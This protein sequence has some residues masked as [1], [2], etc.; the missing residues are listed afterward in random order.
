MSGTC[1]RKVSFAI[2]DV[3]CLRAQYRPGERIVARVTVT[4]I[5]GSE[6]HGRLV[7]T[8]M[9]LA[10]A[11]EGFVLPLDPLPRGSSIIEVIVPPPRLELGVYGSFGLDLALE[12][13]GRVH[14][15]ASTAFDVT[16]TGHE[17]VRYGFLSRFDQRDGGSDGDLDFLLRL[18][19]TDVQFYDWMYRHDTL[20][21]PTEQFEDLM[22]KPVSLAVVRQ[23]IQGCHDR[24]MRALA[25]GAVYA[26]SGKFR[27]AHPDWG[28]YDGAGN[29]YHLIGRFFIM[30]TAR[31]SPWTRHLLG[32]FKA[33]RAELHLDGFHLDSYG[34]PKRALSH[35]TAEPTP[36]RL[37]EDF[38]VFI[39][40]AR[41]E[42]GSECRLI[43]NNVNGWPVETTAGA[44]Q[45][46]VYIEVWPP[47]LR[48]SH[49]AELVR[50]ARRFGG[51]KPIIMAAYLAPFRL[52]PGTAGA[53]NAALL[54]I[55]SLAALGAQHLLFGEEEGVLTQV[56]RGF[57]SP[58]P[59]AHPRARA[60]LRLPGPL[61]G[62]PV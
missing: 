14:D 12:I 46:A 48:Y 29:P 37:D 35:L 49:L 13:D 56:L 5:S 17:V 57:L 52:L 9:H 53:G 55:S 58:R 3:L 21:P 4:N 32:Q 7:V 22:G 62:D 33:A 18:H 8:V 60:V 34:F 15:R 23:K 54:L 38:P 61:F 20:L 40:E 25:Y 28:L 16:A 36:R 10:G 44:P 11:E 31:G 19:V 45:D 2:T 6:T 59:G 41:R 24:G 47:H 50:R 43:F 26:A 39:G 27:E 42:L 51:A 1:S 30:D